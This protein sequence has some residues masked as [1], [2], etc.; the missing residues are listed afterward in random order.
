[1]TCAN[2]DTA[3]AVEVIP[4]QA[5]DA[6]RLIPMVKATEQAVG[7]LDEV[8]TDSG[9]DGDRQRAFCLGYGILP[10]ITN[11]PNRL[12]PWEIDRESYDQ[13]NRVEWLIRQ[14]QT[15]PPGGDA[16]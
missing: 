8:T 5:G 4:G 2:E 3:L 11:R 14:G 6:P 15:V 10:V 1:M 16:V 7:A 9:F 12:E 13:R